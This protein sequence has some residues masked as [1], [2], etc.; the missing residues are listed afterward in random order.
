MPEEE[1][2]DLDALAN[3]VI[4]IDEELYNSEE[5]IDA[6]PKRKNQAG[7][8]LGP[9]RT[10]NVPSVKLTHLIVTDDLP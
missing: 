9:I 1:E 5:F 10:G 4:K 3:R 2:I 6:I 7:E 8:I